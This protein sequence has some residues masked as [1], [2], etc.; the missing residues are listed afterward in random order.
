[1]RI[2]FEPIES[3]IYVGSVGFILGVVV[4]V[5]YLK[6]RRSD[7]GRV[8]D[9]AMLQDKISKLESMASRI[10]IKVSEMKEL[11]EELGEQI[12]LA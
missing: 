11:G 10:N 7:I 6:N 8:I 1:M 9:C 5:W 2:A 12:K 4:S 3:Y